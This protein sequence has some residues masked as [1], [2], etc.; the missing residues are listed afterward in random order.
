[1]CASWPVYPLHSS[2]VGKMACGQHRGVGA[3]SGLRRT[4]VVMWE[5]VSGHE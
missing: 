1:V 5:R 3:V 2:V 4:R